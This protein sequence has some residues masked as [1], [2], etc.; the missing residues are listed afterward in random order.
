MLS[1][2]QCLLI[3]TRSAFDTAGKLWLR[4]PNSVTLAIFRQEATL[5]VLVGGR[6]W[7]GIGKGKSKEWGVGWGKN[8]RGREWLRGQSPRSKVKARFEGPRVKMSLSLALCFR[9]HCVQPSHFPDL[10][11]FILNL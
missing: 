10:F 2:L 6:C 7:K 5:L 11:S 1:P 8:P 4:L 9:L 3:L